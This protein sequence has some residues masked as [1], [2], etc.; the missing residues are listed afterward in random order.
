MQTTQ[1]S[2]VRSQQEVSRANEKAEVIFRWNMS[3]VKMFIV[4]DGTIDDEEAERRIEEYRKYLVVLATFASF[5]HPI[6]K[7]VDD[8]WHAHVL[9]THDYVR[10]CEAAFGYFVHHKP[11]FDA[12]GK[13]KLAENYASN[14][15]P[16]LTELFGAPSEKYWLKC[17]T[18]CIESGSCDDAPGDE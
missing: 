3:R 14:T 11:V 7:E 9:D 5:R 13:K 10:F 8:A 12:A 1:A 16:H 6:S 4:R 15:I 2:P 18:I 17:Q